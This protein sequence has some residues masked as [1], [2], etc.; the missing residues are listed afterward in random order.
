M[1]AGFARSGSQSHPV[2]KILDL[3]MGHVAVYIEARRAGSVATRSW[4]LVELEDDALRNFERHQEREAVKAC[5]TCS[6]S[7]FR[8][9]YWITSL[10]GRSSRA[11]FR[12]GQ[13]QTGLFLQAGC[14]FCKSKYR[15]T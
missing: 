4:P 13:R 3:S 15:Y 12:G 5:W 8:S 9:P 2:K 7:A 14:P 6:G 10:A 11:G 1:L